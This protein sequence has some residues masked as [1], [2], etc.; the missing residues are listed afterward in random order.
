MIKKKYNVGIV[1]FGY[2]GKHHCLAIKKLK[3]L[4][5]LTAVYE[6]NISN[7][8]SKILDKKTKVFSKFEKKNILKNLDI[9]IITL[10]THLHLKFASIAIGNVKNII[11]EKP[12]G[13]KLNLAKKLINK[14]QRKKTTIIVVK[15]LR[16]NPIFVFIK[17]MIKKRMFGKIYY[18]SLDIF[19]NRSKSYFS[20]SNWKGRKK[21]DGGTLFNQISH[22]I[23]LFYWFFGD[24]KKS[25]GFKL[26]DNPK[27]NEHSGQ[28]SI[29]FKTRVFLSINYSLK[30]FG[31]NLKTHFTILG[32]NSS[33]EFNSKKIISK[34]STLKLDRYISKN[35]KKLSKEISKFG[36]GL[37]IFHKNVFNFLK[38]KN[39][40]MNSLSTNSKALSSFKNLDIVSKNM[41]N[42]KI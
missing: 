6:K 19:L 16:F 18:I 28:I 31:N 32:K 4:Y 37:E 3:N 41:N 7:I 34:N 20:N 26:V 11:I 12:L 27:K 25:K 24:I 23:D 17:D 36:K 14:A 29:F 38:N 13:L 40:L 8:N 22:Y 39:N 1:G 35:S 21:L 33:L 42:L 9:L 30:S 10:P 5:N 15:Q 2:I